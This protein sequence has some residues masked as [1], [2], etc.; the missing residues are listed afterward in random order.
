MIAAGRRGTGCPE[1]SH[2]KIYPGQGGRGASLRLPDGKLGK[3]RAQ[4]GAGLRE[5]EMGLAEQVR[6][7]STPKSRVPLRL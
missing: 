7:N 1:S 4:G 2:R 3:I 5:P 6:K